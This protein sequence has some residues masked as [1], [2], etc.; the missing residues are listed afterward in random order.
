MGRRAGGEHFFFLW[1]QK[2]TS[3]LFT[4]KLKRG[5][6]DSPSSPPFSIFSILFAGPYPSLRSPVRVPRPSPTPLFDLDPPLPRYNECNCH[7]SSS[8]ARR[9]PRQAQEDRRCQPHRSSRHLQGVHDVSV[10]S[11]GLSC[12][13]LLSLDASA[14]HCFLTLSRCAF[15]SFGGIFFG[16]D[17]GYI[18]GVLSSSEFIHAIAGPQATAISSS[19]TSLIVS[20]LSAGTFFGAL[21][22][23]DLADMM[24]RRPTIIA[25]CGIVSSI[26]S[27]RKLLRRIC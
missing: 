13:V 7:R 15:A 9:W 14:D 1:R 16:Y 26:S 11:A 6:P 20:I 10:A 5:A 18:N 12:T 19:T 8:G 17:S 25:G 21:I 2:R 24:G 3:T 27:N 23:G 22:A 4:N